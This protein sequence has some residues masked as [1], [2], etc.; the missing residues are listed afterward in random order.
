[1]EKRLSNKVAFVTGEG[2]GIGKETSFFFFEE[3]V[4]GAGTKS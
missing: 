2:S 3:R 4:D 1:M